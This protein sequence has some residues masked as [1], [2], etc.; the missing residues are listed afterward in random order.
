MP[1]AG[2][3]DGAVPLRVAAISFLNPAPL[4][5]HF[6][7]EPTAT[8]L[9][10]RYA[11]HYT[12]P[13]RCAAQLHAG[14]ADLGLIPIAA[15]TPELAVVPGCTIASLHEVRSILLLVRQRGNAPVV[16]SIRAITAIAADSASRS[17]AAYVR[18]LLSRFYGTQPV[19]VEREADPLTM[20]AEQ[21][22]AL[23]IGDHA[24]LAREFRPQID[25]A[26][27]GSSDS[28]L[29]WLDLAELWREHTGLPWVAAVWALRP[30]AL[31]PGEVSPAQLIADLNGSRDAGLAHIGDLV[32]EW[33]GR[34]PLAPETIRTYLSHNIYYHLDEPCLEAIRTFRGYAAELGVLPALPR[35]LHLVKA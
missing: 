1:L 25:A 21:D 28:K 15:L 34:L 18:V 5:Y 13:A 31:A 20:L 17:S 4:L 8:E 9:R 10:T 23:L 3:Y 7:H 16:D 24:L 33:A 14:E 6:E 30:A 22:A 32:T 26:V 2:R 35:T 11:M 27:E 19:L 12:T 29:L